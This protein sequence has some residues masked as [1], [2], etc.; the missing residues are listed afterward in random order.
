MHFCINLFDFNT[1]LRN[2]GA[3]LHQFHKKSKKRA[4]KVRKKLVGTLEVVGGAGELR[5]GKGE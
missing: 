1:Y 2:Y 3:K 4:K 5:V